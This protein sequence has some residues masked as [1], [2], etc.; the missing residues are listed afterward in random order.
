MGTILSH[1]W[2][3]HSMNSQNSVKELFLLYIYLERERKLAKGTRNLIIS[4]YK[5][6]FQLRFKRERERGEEERE[7]K[8]EWTHFS[9]NIQHDHG[10]IIYLYYKKGSL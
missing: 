1:I 5:I 2:W 3:A 7:E 10:E 4:H 6:S 9:L 8:K